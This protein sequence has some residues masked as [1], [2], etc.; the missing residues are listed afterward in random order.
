M[1]VPME[2]PDLESIANQRGWFSYIAGTA[3]YMLNNF[4]LVPTQ[5]LPSKNE[6]DSEFGEQF[7]TNTS[8]LD[9]QS[10]RMKYCLT[11]DNYHTDLPTGKGMSSSAAIC[12][13]TARAFS[14][15]FELDLSVDDEM[16][17][18]YE[19]ERL[20]GS[21]CG[22]LDQVCAYGPGKVI[23]VTFDVVPVPKPFELPSDQS[24]NN[25]NAIQCS[26]SPRP[27]KSP[28]LA[29][30]GQTRMEPSVVLRQVHVG[31]TIYMVIVDLAAYKD[32]RRILSAL[33]ACYPF[34]V[35]PV[36]Q[37]VHHHL[38]S[39]SPKLTQTILKALKMGSAKDLGG[40]MTEY[41][42]DFD[43]NVAPACPSELEAPMLHAVLRNDCIKNLIWGGKGV[44]SQGDGAVQLV[45]RSKEDQNQMM[46]VVVREFPNMRVFPLTIP[47]T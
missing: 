34:P 37:Q 24:Q 18:A 29:L 36:H 32:T 23:D 47:A 3:L 13:L 4:V 44:G 46:D 8:E 42:D 11:I 45:C 9:T 7:Y 28:C 35:S 2:K 41:Q 20:A 27:S 17:C 10:N 19:G 22:R 39:A 30:T 12:V 6:I 43:R 31:E 38:S 15:A 25:D 21:G 40:L 26:A 5:G 1:K 33:Q 14:I 16:R